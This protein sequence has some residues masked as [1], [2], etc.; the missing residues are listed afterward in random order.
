VLAAGQGLLVGGQAGDLA[1]RQ[2]PV[3]QRHLVGG[4]VAGLLT[5]A[6]LSLGCSSAAAVS[7]HS[8][9]RAPTHRACDP[10]T[11]VGGF[12]LS[13]VAAVP[14]APELAQVVG[15]VADGVDQR[16]VWEAE[17][18]DGDCRLLTLPRPLCETPCSGGQ[19]CA[20][21]N[22]CIREPALQDV[23]AVTLSGLTQPVRI[24]GVNN[25]SGGGYGGIYCFALVP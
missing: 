14:P 9:P 3:V 13:L 11:R 17:A 23:G 24:M 1:G 21:E 22:R 4:R 5:V 8:P 16:F 25:T 6:K 18:S 2:G 12:A 19:F 15:M 20:G 7:V 10:V